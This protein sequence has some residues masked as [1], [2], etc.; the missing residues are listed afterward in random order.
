MRLINLFILSLPLL[1]SAQSFPQLQSVLSKIKSFVPSAATVTT[2]DA[3]AA[4]VRKN[5]VPLTLDNWHKTFAAPSVQEASRE[6]YVLVTGGNKSCWGL[7]DAVEKAW[8]V[9]HLELFPQT[10]W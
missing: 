2:S 10:L 3:A 9:S 5:V 4:A 8:K 1:T 7:C 6:W